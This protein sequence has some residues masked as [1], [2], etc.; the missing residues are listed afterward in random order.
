MVW[1]YTICLRFTFS[2]FTRDFN[3]MIFQVVA[4][5]LILKYKISFYQFFLKKLLLITLVLPISVR[6]GWKPSMNKT[7]YVYMCV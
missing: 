7:D 2:S 3:T 4:P 6:D 1:K 5:L